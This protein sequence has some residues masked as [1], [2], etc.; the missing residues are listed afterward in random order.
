MR[1]FLRLAAILAAGSPLLTLFAQEKSD[2]RIAFKGHI[3]AIYSVAFNKDGTLG[4]TASFD[5]S[6]RLWETGS[7]KQLREFSGTNGHQG[8]VLSVAFHPNGDQIASGGADNT[9]R[10]WDV[11][12]TTPVRELAHAASVTAVAVSPDGKTVAGAAKDGSVKLWAAADGKGIAT[13]TAHA[14]GVTGVAFNANSQVLA[15]SGANGMIRF[16]NVA[17]GKPVASLGAHAGPVSG[18]AISPASNQA[19]SVGEDGQ[20]KSWQFPV[21][22]PRSLPAHADGIATLVIS[23]DGNSSLTGGADKSVKLSNSTNG[24]LV[25]EFIGATAAVSALALWPNNAVVAAGATDGKVFLWTA[26]GKLAGTLAAH[27]GAVTGIAVNANGNGFVTAGADGVMRAWAYPLNASKSTAQPDRV[28]RITLSP[29]GKRLITAGADKMVRTWAFPALTAERQFTGHTAIVTAAAITPDNNTILSAGDDETI[30]IWNAANGTQTATLAGHGGAIHALAIAPNGQFAVTGGNDGLVKTWAL[31]VTAPKVYVH[32]DAVTAFA[33]S[34]DGNR[35]VTV[36][37]DK[38]ARI[39]NLTQPAAERTYNLNGQPIT[40][41]AFAPD[42]ATVAIAAVDKTLSIRNG[43][44]EVKKIVLPAEARTIAF[45]STGATV[46]VGLADNN[47]RLF[48]VGDAKEAKS[49]AAHT[50]AVTAMAFSPEG[51]LILTAGADKTVRIW[52]AAATAAKGKIDLTMSPVSLAVSKDGSRFAVGGE[53]SVAVFTLADN[54]AAGAI[55]TPAD[56]KG[57]ALSV[58]GQ[59]VAVACADNR[60]RVYGPDLKLQEV[61]VHDG[62]ATGVAFHPDGKRVVSTSA[63]KSLRLWNPALVAQAAHA[64]PVRQLFI[65][66]DGARVLSAGDDK[67]LRIWDAKTGKEQKAI[68]AGDAAITALSAT[69]DAAK[70]ATAGADKTAKVW[71]LADGKAVTT[72]SLPGPGQTVAISP[73]GSRLAV[74]FAEGTANRL[75]VYDAVGGRELQALPDPAGTVRSLLFLADNRTLIVAGDDKNLTTHDVAV[76]AAVAVHT[77]G[78]AGVALNPASPQALTAGADK[79]IKLWDL[80]TGKE[81]RTVATLGEAVTNLTVSRDFA[82]VSAAA[83]K[84]AKVIQVADGKEVASLAH[85]ADVVSMN[86]SADK[87]RLI[88]GAADNVAR[89]W[90]VAT[91]RLLQTFSHTGAVRGVAFH[92]SQPLVVTASADKTAA[93]QPFALTRAVPVSTKPLRA[94]VP[95]PDS[96]R[97]VITGDDGVVHIMN[98][99]NGTEERRIEGAP[100]PLYAV[101]LSKNLQILATAGADKTLRLYTFNDGK[102]VGKIAAAAPVR[103]LALSADNRLLVGVADD[104]SVTAW[105]VGF[106]PGQPIPDDFGKEVQKFTHADATVAVAFTEKGELFTG[107][108]DKTVKQWKV[109]ANA[110]TRNLAHPNLVDAVAWS[111]DGKLLATACHDGVVRVFDIEKNAAVKTINAHTTPQPSPVYSV[112]WTADGK[113]LLSTSFDKSMKLWDANSGNL[114]REFKAFAEKGFEKGHQD[115]VFCAAI[116]K[117]GKLIAS[118]SSDRRIKLWNAADGNVIREFPHPSIK[119][120]PGQSHPGGVYQLRFTADEKFLVSVGPA[121]KNRGYVAVWNVADGKLVAGND[122]AVGPVFGLALSPDGKSLLLGCGPKLRQVS[123][124]E[125]V[126]IPLPK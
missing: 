35:I 66:P 120:E 59:R 7:G 108:A 30:R 115:Q 95:T 63:D 8:L 19:Y 122:Y 99:A 70:V 76:Q 18:V 23:A 44:K 2:G 69:A 119:G 124:A 106:Q 65:T 78:A 72:V 34:S 26:D 68:A 67:Q 31:P 5:K 102:E 58:D 104:K 85:Q 21:P 110:P 111:P 27:T 48:A 61:F 118:G 82:L 94:I 103:G 28:M 47:V 12:L 92:P 14:G 39:W 60:I 84:T 86:F 32:P 57:I 109:A 22:A 54:K 6:V 38:Q 96:A 88:T 52:D 81:A 71:T 37:A 50:A 1:T 24:Q 46:A 53:K 25:R 75:R 77:G 112:T 117:D 15:T 4:A 51:D 40:A 29:D 83:G 64:G 107:S 45:N 41:V 74:A 126:I 73:N 101:A 91:G 97:L 98:A 36:A 17:D 90:E 123:E 56:V 89:V 114:V 93:V 13:I 62:A 33:M 11:P 43:D 116:T 3:E 80:A 20:L 79:T 16:W 125:A 105:N 42:N 55:T 49:S 113:Q 121:P 10:V 87:A 100:G 9:A